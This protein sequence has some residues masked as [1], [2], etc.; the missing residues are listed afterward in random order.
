MRIPAR[1]AHGQRSQCHS[2]RCFPVALDIAT[3]IEGYP[4]ASTA[5]PIALA[6]VMGSLDILLS[7]MSGR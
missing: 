1:S 3:A 5:K 4:L 6:R 7:D 2:G